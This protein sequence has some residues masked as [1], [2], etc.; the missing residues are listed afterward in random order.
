[1][2]ALRL[3]T[4]EGTTTMKHQTLTSLALAGLILAAACSKPAA[5]TEPSIMAGNAFI[6]EPAA[7][8]DVTMAGVDISASGGDF[9]MVGARSAIADSIELHTM[10]MDDGQMRM[11]KVDGFDIASGE[12]LQLKRGADHMMVF[13]L[14]SVAAG[15]KHTVTLE[16]I[17][18][19]G[20]NTQIDVP[21]VV[22][23]M[24]Q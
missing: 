4:D 14:A 15:E 22:R 23:A 10:S 16:F 17:G 8:R 1:M 12:T 21:A 24:G 20:E 13:G 2:P 19:D 11:R 6:L 7:G 3:A 5:P 9:R 18:P